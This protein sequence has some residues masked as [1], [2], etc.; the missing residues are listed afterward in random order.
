MPATANI[1]VLPVGEFD[2]EA[3]RAEFDSIVQHFAGLGA[4]VS[5]ADPVSDE[6]AA[7]QAVEAAAPEAPPDLLLLIPLRGLS[8]QIMEAAALAT[9]APCLIWPVQG[10]FALPSSTLAV[11]ALREAGRPVELLFAPPNHPTALESAQ[12]IVRAAAA[13]SR[14]RRSR[15]GVIGGLFPNLIAA[16]YDPAVIS[17]RL[18]VTLLP[19]SYAEIRAGIT[20]A[21]GR[22]D[23][24]RQA[25]QAL[26]QAYIITP[27]D[28]PS[29][30]PGLNLHLALQRLAREHHFDAFA[31]E[32]WTGLPKELG[33]N[34]CLGFAG[35]AYTLACEGDVTL[36]I[37]LLLVQYLT[38]QR[39][40]VGDLYDLNLDGIMTLIHCGAPASLAR[41]KRAVVLGRSKIALERGYETLTCRPRLEPGPVT[42]FRYYGRACD[43][44]HLA[45]GELLGSE[46]SPNLSV[47]VRL[48]G[49]R[50]EFLKLVA[51]NH[52]VVVPGDIRPELSLLA[53]WLD[54][55]I[56]QT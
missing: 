18:G 14:I 29:I 20:S 11:G 30:E 40:Y 28:Q 32:C 41:D 8:A 1:T 21:A 9:E 7:R 46:Q 39:A 55:T 33:L 3:I 56:H 42:V 16:R 47:Q 19:L 4:N 10:R 43:Q 22:T 38:G 5:V 53:R 6:A 34:P 50:W 49:S 37:S 52:Y 35:D 48:A 44:L 12:A 31:A 54:I 13:L 15:I 26:T 36:C 17:A 2:T 24:T 45:Q 27:E 25:R 23:E 51:G